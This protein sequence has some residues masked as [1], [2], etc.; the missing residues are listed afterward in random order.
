MIKYTRDDLEKDFNKFIERNKAIQDRANKIKVFHEDAVLFHRIDTK[1]LATWLFTDSE[2]RAK[3]DN[4]R[5]SWYGKVLQISPL[6]HP[7]EFI[8][9]KKKSL[10]VGDIITFNSDTP[11]S[12]NIDGFYE[13]WILSINNILGLD[14]NFDIEKIYR[15]NLEKKLSMVSNQ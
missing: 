5:L 2:A 12:L 15:E 14:E 3:K 1:E 10:K 9:F 7:D 11:F 13:I 6:P 8:E 4:V